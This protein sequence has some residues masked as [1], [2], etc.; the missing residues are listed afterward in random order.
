[1]ASSQIVEKV[2]KL[3]ALS[4]SSNINEATTSAAIATRLIIQHRLSEVE[5]IEQSLQDQTRTREYFP[6]PMFDDADPVY[7][8]ARVSPWK[9]RLLCVI[10]HHC[11]CAVWNDKDY[12]ATPGGRGVSRYRLIGQYND[13]QLVRQM[14]DSLC[15]QIKYFSDCQYRGYGQVSSTSFCA[16]AVQGLEIVFRQARAHEALQAKHRGQEST[17][18]RL[19]S[20]EKS[21]QDYMYRVHQ[22]RPALPKAR[23]FD[24]DAYNNGN[25]VGSHIGAKLPPNEEG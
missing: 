14:F 24:S 23:T 21:A 10:A 6:E 12:K 13:V 16:G 19:R 15:E 25:D 11:G 1:M 4:R 3:L 2:K 8:S 20:R 7:E 5:I 18:T 22:L 17:L 9:V